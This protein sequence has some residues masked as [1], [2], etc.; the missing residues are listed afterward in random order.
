MLIV[1]T[2]RKR[3]DKQPVYASRIGIELL[4]GLSDDAKKELQNAGITSLERFAKMKSPK[5]HSIPC[6]K[7]IRQEISQVWRVIQEKLNS[8]HD[9]PK[10]RKFDRNLSEDDRRTL[11]ALD[12]FESLFIKKDFAETVRTIVPRAFNAYISKKKEKPIGR[13]VHLFH[14]QAS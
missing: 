1:K 12:W 5:I 14:K 4:S 11:A 2:G 10:K 7:K 6:G 8:V 13:H 3:H 9:F